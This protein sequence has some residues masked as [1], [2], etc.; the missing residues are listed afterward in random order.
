MKDVEQLIEQVH[1]A[2][3]RK[4]EQ[5]CLPKTEKELRTSPKQ[6]PIVRELGIG[7][8]LWRYAAVVALVVAVMIVI[9][10][11]LRQESQMPQMAHADV[12]RP[13]SQQLEEARKTNALS[14]PTTS[15]TRYAYTETADGVRVY[16]D[17]GCDADEV[18]ERMQRVM[19]TLEWVESEKL[20][21]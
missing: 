3:R 9:Q 2:N 18:I 13:V 11:P 7:R 17:D 12:P 19:E 6:R 4:L 15:E 5:S 10:L 14:Q 16:C 21:N 8:H 20:E 1:A